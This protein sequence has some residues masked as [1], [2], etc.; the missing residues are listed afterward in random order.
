VQAANELARDG[1]RV[2][3]LAEA[4]YE[5]WGYASAATA[6]SCLNRGGVRRPG[7]TRWNGRAPTRAEIAQLAKIP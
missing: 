4:I 2:R 1:V 5:T 6:A 3:E 7:G